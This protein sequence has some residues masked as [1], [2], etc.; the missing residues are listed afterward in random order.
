MSA[1]SIGDLGYST[2]RGSIR[3]RLSPRHK[4]RDLLDE[5]K[6]FILDKG[7]DD[8]QRY[9]VIEDV[10]SKPYAEEFLDAF[11]SIACDKEEPQDALKAALRALYELSGQYEKAADGLMAAFLKEDSR[12]QIGHMNT[13]NGVLANIPLGNYMQDIFTAVRNKSMD[14]WDRKRIVEGVSRSLSRQSQSYLEFS[15]ATIE[16][17]A[18]ITEENFLRVSSM[19]S[20]DP[21][22][23]REFLWALRNDG[24]EWVRSEAIKI[25]NQAALSS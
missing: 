17:S 11:A 2:L 16:V 15:T 14:S 4:V 25:L 10:S 12:R 1:K 8:Y 18:D 22:R 3:L 24:D 5:I 13:E 19:H 23:H 6:E 7:N 20:L 21:M 9:L